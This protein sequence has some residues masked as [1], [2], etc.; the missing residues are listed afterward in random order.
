M[1]S[2][3][4]PQIHGNSPQFWLNLQ[5]IYD[6]RIAELKTDASIKTLPK[7]GPRGTMHDG[8]QPQPA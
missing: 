7:L 2:L 8:R 1:P 4:A 6:L 5:T 3:D